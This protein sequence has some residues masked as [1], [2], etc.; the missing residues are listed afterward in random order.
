MP[1]PLSVIRALEFSH[2]VMGSACGMVLADLGADVIKIEP[3]SL[4]DNTRRLTGSAKGF[5]PTIN[6]NKR[7]LCIDIKRPSGLALVRRLATGSD[8]L[9][10]N[11]RPGAMDKLGL[12]HPA[13]SAINSR[14]VYCSCK[15]FLPGPYEHRAALDEVVQMMGCLA[16]MTGMPGTPFRA[17]S[18]VNDIMGGL[19]AVVAVMAALRERNVTGKGSL[20]Q[21][22][23]FET[24][25]VLVAQPMA[26]AAIDGKD[27]PPFGEPG[28][29]KPWPIYDVFDTATAG[30][31]VFVGVVTETQ[32]RA[33]CDAF[34][35]SD[36]LNDPSLATMVQLAGARSILTPRIAK[37]FGALSKADLM[38]RCEALG[39]PYAPI[40][41][42][43]DLFEDPH[44][45][46]SGGLLPTELTS[47]ENPMGEQ[48]TNY[49]GLPGLP[50]SF[51]DGRPGWHRQP[52]TVGEH[53]AEILAEAGLADAEIAALVAEGTLTIRPRIAEAAE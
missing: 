21:S 49:T 51:R 20:I 4:G 38:T 48:L 7:S 6:R 34:E 29:P 22:G 47:A 52:P 25:M 28:L 8:V 44:L 18:S 30:A 26:Q 14:L 53:G 13:L 37:V 19:F 9:L 16:Y 46:A 40:S 17:G 23:L 3:S 36:L 27:P 32:W 12:G 31:Q 10:E 45:L 15:G 41:R 5:F 11:F 50:I 43:A 39:L 33:F 1:G 24:N 42:P 2:M 35:L